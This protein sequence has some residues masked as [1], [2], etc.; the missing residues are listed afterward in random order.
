[1]G[2]RQSENNFNSDNVKIYIIQKIVNEY[3][4]V[5]NDMEIIFFVK[6]DFRNDVLK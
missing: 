4:L 3:L 1:M 2:S 6:E 5:V